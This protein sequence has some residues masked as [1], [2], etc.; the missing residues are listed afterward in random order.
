MKKHPLIHG[1]TCL[2][3][4]DHR[5]RPRS[6]VSFQSPRY[7]AVYLG[8]SSRILQDPGLRSQLAFPLFVARRAAPRVDEGARRV[9]LLA[10]ELQRHVLAL[11][12]EERRMELHVGERLMDLDLS[13]GGL[14][15]EAAWAAALARLVGCLRWLARVAEAA[16]PLLEQGE[17]EAEGA[18]GGKEQV[19]HGS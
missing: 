4:I 2:S 19:Q 6:Q 14:R 13:P 8:A 1:P 9:C 17:A 18:P 10:A 16:M 12:R 5:P 7:R 3:P 15:D 11:D